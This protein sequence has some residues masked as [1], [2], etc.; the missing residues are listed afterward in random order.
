MRAISTRKSWTSRYRIS[1]ITNDTWV[2][3]EKLLVARNTEQYQKV[4][5]RIPKLPIEQGAIY[6]KCRE[7][8]SIRNTSRIMV[9]N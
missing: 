9:G 1:R 6:E 4:C 2:N 5:S 8:S 7:T 3:Q